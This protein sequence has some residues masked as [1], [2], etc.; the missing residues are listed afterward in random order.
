ML[1]HILD[2]CTKITA[3]LLVS[4]SLGTTMAVSIV[5]WCLVRSWPFAG[6]CRF[7]SGLFTFLS[8]RPIVSQFRANGRNWLGTIIMTAEKRKEEKVK[9]S[10][11]PFATLC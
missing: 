8:R 10:P 3:L 11:L 4:S 2:T 7:L 6:T 1:A 9:F 5:H